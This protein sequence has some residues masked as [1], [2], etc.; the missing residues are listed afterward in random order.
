[1]I[2][3]TKCHN[4]RRYVLNKETTSIELREYPNVNCIGT[5]VVLE[6]LPCGCQTLDGSPMYYGCD[7]RMNGFF[8][9]DDG[10]TFMAYPIRQCLNTSTGDS[11]KYN[12]FDGN[13]TGSLELGMPKNTTI[14]VQK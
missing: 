12:V 14:D 2:L 11:I 13:Y 7:L 5:G 1:M 10:S 4:R 9:Q 3:D 8:V 6:T